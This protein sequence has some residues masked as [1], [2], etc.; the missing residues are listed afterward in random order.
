M[1]QVIRKFKL[2]FAQFVELGAF[3]Q[4]AFDL[5]KATQNHLS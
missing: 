1:K 3:A 5:N 4:F 2:E